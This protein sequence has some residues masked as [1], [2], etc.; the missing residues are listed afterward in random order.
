MNSPSRR[1]WIVSLLFVAAV[2]NY[3]DK[4]ALALLAPTIQSD[5]GL[6]DQAYAN[7]QNAFQ[8]AYT[9]ALL[10][11]GLIVDRFGP[12]MSLACFVC[13][14]SL[15]NVFTAVARSATSLGCF[16]FLLGLGEAGNWAA[17]LKSV[18]AWFP[19][20]ERGLAIGIYTAGTPIGM[21]LAPLLI[22]GLAEGMGWRMA[23]VITGLA[24]LVWLIPWLFFYRQPSPSSASTTGDDQSHQAV[25]A[26]ITPTAVETSWTWMQL[27]GRSEVWC[28]LIGRMLS[29]PIWFFY[30]N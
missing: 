21:T 8:V 5:L 30:Q 14:W 19:A 3:V 4:N 27:F 28:L 23:F 26:A 6:S 10:A 18:S 24:G 16:R 1:W 22:I 20:R 7:I 13:W 9:L 29:D 15:A 2:L 12:R 17:S 11:S 25:A